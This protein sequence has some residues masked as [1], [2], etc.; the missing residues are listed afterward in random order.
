[1]N[2]GRHL[3]QTIG[4][5]DI[6][7]SSR[8]RHLWGDYYSQDSQYPPS[9]K[10]LKKTET[11]EEIREVKKYLDLRFNCTPDRMVL[12]LRFF[13]KKCSA[14]PLPIL[15]HCPHLGLSSRFGLGPLFS[16]VAPS[17]FGSF[18]LSNCFSLS[19]YLTPSL[20]QNAPF[21]P[22]RKATL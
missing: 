17:K 7:V 16:I 11:S 5:I 2:G 22:G 1:M 6:S 4:I 8:A 20:H 10:N 3:D 15:L 12:S 13:Q 19:I 18:A 21:P 9:V 14:I